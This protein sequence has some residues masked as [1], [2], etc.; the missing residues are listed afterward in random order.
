MN[1]VD[2]LELLMLAWS[3]ELGPWRT[4]FED[5]PRHGCLVPAQAFYLQAHFP[6]SLFFSME[7]SHWLQKECCEDPFSVVRGGCASVAAVALGSL[8]AK[9]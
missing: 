6:L 4:R 3:L 2:A 7:C 5:G 1:F 8:E 9:H